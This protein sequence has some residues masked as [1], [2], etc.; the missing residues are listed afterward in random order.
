MIKTILFECKVGY[1]KISI[2]PRIANFYLLQCLHLDP[3]ETRSF[4]NFFSFEAALQY[5]DKLNI[6]GMLKQLSL[7]TLA[8][9]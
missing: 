2:N 8:C 1:T 6:R 4:K 3:E 7:Y 5:L 9:S